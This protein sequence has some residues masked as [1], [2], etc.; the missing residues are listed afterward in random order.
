MGGFLSGYDIRGRNGA[1]MNISHLLFADD[2]LVFCKD[3]EEQMVFL[4][5]FLLCFKALS[6]LRVVETKKRRVG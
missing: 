3:S 1:T 6:R 4:S 2:T 5:W